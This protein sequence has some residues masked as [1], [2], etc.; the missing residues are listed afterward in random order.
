MKS[1][2]N[3][4]EDNIIY[5]KA[6]LKNES[7]SKPLLKCQKKIITLHFFGEEDKE[8]LRSGNISLLRRKK[9]LEFCK[10][11]FTQ[12]AL[13]TQED[14]ALLLCTSLSTIKR[15]I[16]SLNQEGFTV[17]TRG[18]IKDVGRGISFKSKII[19]YYKKGITIN[20]IANYLWQDEYII[21]QTIDEYQEVLDL[22]NK[23]IPIKN[24][25]I[26]T[27]ISVKIIKEYLKI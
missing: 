9:I 26:I 1:I 20:Q 11:A 3:Y 17:P 25:H 23:N 10:E 16:L 2:N 19:K 14:L 7:I 12:G 15:D 4:I 21:I 27:N 13:L 24:I 22:Y 18:F 5:Y 6:V 8:F